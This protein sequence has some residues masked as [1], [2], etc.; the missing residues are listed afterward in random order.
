MLE[1]EASDP[2]M[3]NARYLN[4]LDGRSMFY[5]AKPDDRDR[6]DV[7]SYYGDDIEPVDLMYMYVK[8]IPKEWG[9]G[10]KDYPEKWFFLVAGD[11][12]ILK[13][14]PLTLRHNKYPIVPC[15]PDFDGHTLAPISR[16]E[17][18]KGMQQTINFMYNTRF[19]NIRKSVNDMF[20]VDPQVINMADIT[21][22]KEGM[23]VRIR[24]RF[25]GQGK[26]SEA[27]HQFPVS[28]VT[29]SH[30]SSD[31]PSILSLSEQVTCA[32]Q[33]LQGLRRTTSERVTASE[34][35]SIQSNALSRL[36]TTA[37]I[38]SSMSMQPLAYFFAEHAQQFMESGQYV[39]ITGRY[40][41]DLRAIY[42]K[43]GA[44]YVSPDD[45]NV[46]YDIHEHD[47]SIPGSGDP[48]A[49]TQLMQIAAQNPMIFPNL[50]FTKL[51]LYVAKTSGAKNF[52]DFVKT[53]NNTN[54]AV[55]SDEEVLNQVNSGNMIP[56]KGVM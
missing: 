35:N 30:L 29:A 5:E 52:Q 32:T 17:M 24:E 27:M 36:E 6:Y 26:I 18:M 14:E 53:T 23:L 3:F 28:D 15:C 44:V 54:M 33:N 38:I 7:M 8:I 31:V 45:I 4:N 25:W 47:G 22:P 46:S 49:L 19:A 13:A 12:L 20:L 40:E 56:L 50:D 16:L 55:R 43:Q 48:Q 42:N 51:L 34:A 41:E 2:F 9:L 10:P 39:K 21:N 11:R 1:E 37:R